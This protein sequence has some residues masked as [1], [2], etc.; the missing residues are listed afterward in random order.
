M[1][2]EMFFVLWFPVHVLHACLTHKP[3]CHGVKQMTGMR[4]LGLH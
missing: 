3:V 1:V 4:V 2:E